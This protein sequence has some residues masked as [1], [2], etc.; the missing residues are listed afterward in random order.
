M[1]KAVNL[2]LILSILSFTIILLQQF[3]LAVTI[4]AEEPPANYISNL[5][6]CTP[7]VFKQTQQGVN[8][9]YAIK[10]KLPNN[11]CDV[12]ITTTSDLSD[13]RNRKA[14][15]EMYEGFVEMGIA[16]AKQS[17]QELDRSKIPTKE[18]IMKDIQNSKEITHCKFSQTE[19]NELYSAW[20][21]HDNTNKP[22]QKTEKGIVFE[23]DS[24]KM[25][26]YN[27]LMM[28]YDQGP[29]ST[30]N[31][32]DPK[33]KSTGKRYACEYAD[34]T[35]YITIEGNASYMT[36]TKDNPNAGISNY[37]DTVKK[38]ALSG[39]CSEL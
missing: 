12:T 17:G 33:K 26:S 19:R 21:K 35:C 9:E 27:A 6:T 3:V 23:W 28:K 16:M 1:K 24:S 39:M 5:K 7:G 8:I 37:I 10:G 13:S 34:T 31:T 14:I 30:Y 18:E 4:V 15:E 2:L 29:C 22:A 38:H 36:C 11:R 20:Q 25:G 32:N